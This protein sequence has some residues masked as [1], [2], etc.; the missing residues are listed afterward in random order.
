MFNAYFKH[1]QN[2]Y[3]AFLLQVILVRALTER[4]LGLHVLAVVAHDLGYPTQLANQTLLYIDV[5]RGNLSALFSGPDL[6][7]R[8][9]LFVFVIVGVTVVL[10]IVVVVTMVLMRHQDRQ[11]R[12]YYAKEEEAKVG[13]VKYYDVIR[14]KF[15]SQA[16]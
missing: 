1:L 13:S 3:F 12:L 11:R 16:F 7:Y 8:N 14:R 10:S 15:S 5:F 4:D 6:S 2:V 9:A